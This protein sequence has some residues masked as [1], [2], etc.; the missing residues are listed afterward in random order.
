MRD[1]NIAGGSTVAVVG[2]ISRDHRPG[3]HASRMPV[4]VPRYLC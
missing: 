3:S 1:E 4:V 2:G